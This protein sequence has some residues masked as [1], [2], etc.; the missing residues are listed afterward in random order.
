M[1]EIKAL[2]LFG[3]REYAIKQMTRFSG[4]QVSNEFKASLPIL[5]V[6]LAVEKLNKQLREG[7]E[8]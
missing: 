5:Q 1:P 2:L 7:K 6:S 4:E 8:Q 3:G